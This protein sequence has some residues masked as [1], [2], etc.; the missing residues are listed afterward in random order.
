MNED[1]YEGC[2]LDW[3][4]ALL[5]SNTLKDGA[6]TRRVLSRFTVVYTGVLRH[7]GYFNSASPIGD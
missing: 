5:Y 1:L 3:S 6:P 2:K 7:F 4:I